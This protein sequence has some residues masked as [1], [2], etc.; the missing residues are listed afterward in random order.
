MVEPAEDE[1]SDSQA[2]WDSRAARYDE[3]FEERSGEAHALRARLQATLKLVGP[4]PGTA[5]DAGMGPGRLCAELENLGWTVYGV[6]ASSEMVALARARLPDA[7]GRLLQGRIE[8]LPFPDATFDRVTATGVLEYTVVPSALSDL[9]RV[10]RPNGIAV[11]SYPNPHA[12]Y[13]IWKSWF[14]YPAIRGLRGLRAGRPVRAPRGADA[15]PPASFLSLLREA[16]LD[17]VSRCHTSVLPIVAPFDT[18]FPR[19]AASI[20][21]RL[22]GRARVGSFLATQV[23]YVARKPA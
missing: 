18:V 11:V 6:D 12:L 10:L 4:G 7:A 15:I 1:R 19:L 2:F 17:P 22:E 21:R 20:A 23:V 13:R 5:L 9:A 16:G 8:S 14:Y 3:H